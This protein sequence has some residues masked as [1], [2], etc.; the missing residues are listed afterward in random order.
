MA[1][2]AMSRRCWRTTPMSGRR[3]ARPSS[4]TRSDFLRGV[5]EA[6]G[7]GH[8]SGPLCVVHP[9]ALVDSRR[10]SA[11]MRNL[12]LAVAALVLAAGGVAGGHWLWP[13]SPVATMTPA[14]TTS[15]VSGVDPRWLPACATE[16]SD[17][18]CYWDARARGNKLGR[19]F[20]VDDRNG[21]HYLS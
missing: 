5:Q 4:P 8:R 13:N 14:S 18:P 21:V 6:E 3:S 10:Y 11:P 1:S 7:P 2:S 12:L 15:T 17:G 9:I 19:S 16:D 20:W